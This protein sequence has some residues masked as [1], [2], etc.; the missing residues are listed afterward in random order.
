M[1][2]NLNPEIICYIFGPVIHH[3]GYHNHFSR[4]T[5]MPLFI[6]ILFFVLSI[7]HRFLLFVFSIVHRFF[8]FVLRLCAIALPIVHHFLFFALHLCALVLPI[9]FDLVRFRVQAVN[10]DFINAF[11][12]SLTTYLIWSPILLITSYPFSIQVVYVWSVATSSMKMYPDAGSIKTRMILS[13]KVTSALTM[14]SKGFSKLMSP[15]CS[16]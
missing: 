5:V 9:V 3:R 13:K 2:I 8:S 11:A 7:V 12:L 15:S 1:G 10:A 4:L 6:P 14:T 16:F